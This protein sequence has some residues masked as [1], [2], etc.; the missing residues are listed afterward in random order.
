MS[1]ESDAV[2]VAEKE[3]EAESIKQRLADAE[4][5]VYSLARHIQN[6]DQFKPIPWGIHGISLLMDVRDYDAE[7]YDREVRVPE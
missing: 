4:R 7:R 3:L 5:L 6:N 2:G 1:K